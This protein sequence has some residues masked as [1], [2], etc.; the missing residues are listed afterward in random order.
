M[1]TRRPE[2]G[3]SLQSVSPGENVVGAGAGKSRPALCRGS[4]FLVSPILKGRR[5]GMSR[6]AATSINRSRPPNRTELVVQ[7]NLLRMF[8]AFEMFQHAYAADEITF[9]HVEIF[10]P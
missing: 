2:G 9:M 3:Y 6:R 7:G 8:K 4:H 1:L 5:R 10:T